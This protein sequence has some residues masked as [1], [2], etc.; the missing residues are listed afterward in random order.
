MT[1]YN[2]DIHHRRNVRLQ[3]YDYSQA[4]LYFVTICVQNHKC[5]FGEIIYNEMVLNEIGKMIE[6]W[7]L[8]L[9]NKFRDIVIDKH[10]VMPNHF[11]SIIINTG[12]SVG[13][14]LR[15]CPNDII[16]DKPKNILGEHIGSPLQTVVQWFKTMTTNEYIRGVKTSGWTPFDKRLWQRNYHEHII[17]NEIAHQKIANYIENNHLNWNNDKYYVQ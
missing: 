11:H 7:C 2:P 5:L 10:I 8:E 17:R 4:G 13:A 12:E 14:D 16:L 9:S 15:V 3:D 1:K 6:K